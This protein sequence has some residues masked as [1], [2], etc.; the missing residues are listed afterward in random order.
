MKSLPNSARNFRTIGNQ[1]I[2]ILKR[3]GKR[4]LTEFLKEGTRVLQSNPIEVE[5]QEEPDDFLS[6]AEESDEEIAEG[7]STERESRLEI[8]NQK[9]IENQI[10]FEREKQE[11]VAAMQALANRLN[12]L[13]LDHRSD[14][15]PL[16]GF[17]DGTED[18]EA[19]LENFNV[20]GTSRGWDEARCC[21]VL[22]S[23]LRGTAKAIYNSLGVDEKNTWQNLWIISPNAC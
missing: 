11:K 4:L 9:R 23:Y 12:Q 8:R 16:P 18:F 5:E 22:P 13:E 7:P 6:A 15:L 17:F 3:I 10:R 2:K 21:K 19:Y 1:T 20:I 14:G